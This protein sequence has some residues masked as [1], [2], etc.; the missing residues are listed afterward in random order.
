MA[1]KVCTKFKL[2]DIVKIRNFNADP[3]LRGRVGKIVSIG[4]L[5]SP[6][7]DFGERVGGLTWDLDGVL[8]NSTGRYM[9]SS[10]LELVLS[11][12]DQ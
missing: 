5:S 12:W 1:N 8:S 10:C 6:G 11:E 4:T 9:D 3:D 7:V 2:G